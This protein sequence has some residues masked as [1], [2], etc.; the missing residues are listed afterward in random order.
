MNKNLISLAVAGVL[1]VPASANAY[2]I[3]GKKLEV[4]GKVH[5]SV[6]AS[7]NDRAAP[8]N[9]KD[10]S[11]SSNSS[12]LGFKGQYDMQNGMAALYQIEQ[13][14]NLD[15]GGDT[16]ATRNSFIGLKGSFGTVL[17]GIHDTPFKDVAGK[18]DMF[19]DTI[20]DRRAILGAGATLGNKMNQRGKNALMYKNKFGDLELRAMYSSDAAD[21]APGALDNNNNDMGSIAV[22][23]HNGPLFLAAGYEKWSNLDGSLGKA[24][25][26]RAAGGYKFG[27]AKLGVVYESIKTDDPAAVSLDRKAWGINGSF[28]VTKATAIKAQYMRAG[29]YKGVSNS[30]ASVA[31]LGVF[32]KIDKYNAV[33]AAYTRTSNDA[34]AKYQGVDGGHH[35]EVKT[36]LGGSPS[37]FSVGYV[38]KF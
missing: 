5:M 29:D 21:S 36:D 27:Q 22:F 35:D 17:A 13:E 2:E 23:Y 24:K 8:N 1:A 31:T 37:A 6:D 16:F 33:Y 34:N 11:V 12:R 14:V 15:S 32:N 18:W 28:N 3:L 9:Q 7:N 19:G 20:G 25:G 4:Y 26:W 30:G 38:F 10:F